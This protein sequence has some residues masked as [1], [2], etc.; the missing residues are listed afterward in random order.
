MKLE[1]P[2]QGLAHDTK[3]TD[4]M[5]LPVSGTTCLFRIVSPHCG[6]HFRA[7]CRANHQL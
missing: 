1:K 7:G 3:D 6:L 2:P 4:L 5:P